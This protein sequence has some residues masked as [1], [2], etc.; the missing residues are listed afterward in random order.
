MNKFLLALA[1]TGLCIGG[2]L[3]KQH[4]DD[5]YKAL[6][7]QGYRESINLLHERFRPDRDWATRLRAHETD[8]M[9]RGLVG[10]ID[11]LRREWMT[12]RPIIV[13]AELLEIE[14]G[15]SLGANGIGY[16]VRAKSSFLGTL[17]AITLADWRVETFC[18]ESAITTSV[19]NPPIGEK[20]GIVLTLLVDDIRPETIVWSDT[21][22]PIRVP[23]ARGTCLQA[24]VVSNVDLI[25]ILDVGKE[26]KSQVS[27]PAVVLG[28]LSCVV[29]FAMLLRRRWTK[30]HRE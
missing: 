1:I 8:P 6:A 7:E 25:G 22:P 30:I 28:G 4:A 20:Y 16:A 13:A 2:Y 10:S 18:P 19:R 23:L 26:A 12:G 15:A 3:Q 24:T 27:I 21:K 9:L 14:R 11:D 29:I 17:S 5:R